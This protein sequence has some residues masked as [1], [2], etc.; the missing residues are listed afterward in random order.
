MGTQPH[1]G[2]LPQPRRSGHLIYWV[3]GILLFVLLGGVETF[4]FFPQVTMLLGGGASSRRTRSDYIVAGDQHFGTTVS[5]S[6]G[7]LSKPGFFVL[8]RGTS[9]TAPKV[10]YLGS[11]R[12]YP[13]GEFSD[14]PIMINPKVLENPLNTPKPGES[15]SVYIYY[16][17]GSNVLNLDSDAVAEDSSGNPVMTTM[18][19]L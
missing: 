12:H 7:A 16:D 3:I 19:V 15:V 10:I 2:S 14:I 5:V 11:S 8:M 4:I 17:D 6:K 9:L 18:S 1:V 13:S